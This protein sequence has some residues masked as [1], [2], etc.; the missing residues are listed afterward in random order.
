MQCRL[1][2]GCHSSRIPLPNGWRISQYSHPLGDTVKKTRKKMG[3]TQNQVAV[4]IDSDE[5]TIMNIEK[6]KANTT[7]EVL[8]PLIRTLRID[9]KDIFCP[10][11]DK[12]SPA[13]YQLQ[14]L[15][16]DC[17]EEEA[18]AL[19]PVCQAVISALRANDGILIKEKRACLP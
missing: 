9:P 14:L 12:E 1:W 8:Y 10:E 11:M 16:N 7:M 15:I 17:S 3:L 19:I 18:A 13:H 2:Q 6:Y 5:R 4:L